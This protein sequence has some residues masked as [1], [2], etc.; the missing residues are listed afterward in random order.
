MAAIRVMVAEQGTVAD[1]ESFEP[2]DAEPVE[3]P[4]AEPF[5]P[6]DAG[7]AGS[8]CPVP[9]DVPPLPSVD[10]VADAADGVGEDVAEAVDPDPADAPSSRTPSPWLHAASVSVATVIAAAA[11]IRVRWVRA[12]M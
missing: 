10:G 6:P 5:E 4:D 9:V 1:A 7:L 3:P 8:P 2:P 11:S 12:D